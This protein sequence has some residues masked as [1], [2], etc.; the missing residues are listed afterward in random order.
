MHYK[1]WQLTGN[2]LHTTGRKRVYESKT[3]CSVEGCNNPNNLKVV[4]SLCLLHYRRVMRSGRVELTS[5][6]ERFEEKFEVTEDCWEWLGGKNLQGYGKFRVGKRT[7][8]AHV[9]SYELYVGEIVEDKVIDHLCHNT[10]CVKPEH[11]QAVSVK[12]NAENRKKTMPGSRS[13]RLNVNWIAR[14]SNW[15]A[16]I[17]HNGKVYYGKHRNKYELHCAHRDAVQLRMT[18]YTNNILDRK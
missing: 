15:Q 7:L 3:E 11:L 14:T 12:E 5:V 6:R 10:S 1:R 2:P 8:G 16:S 9:V 17:M 4:R 18:Y 13:G